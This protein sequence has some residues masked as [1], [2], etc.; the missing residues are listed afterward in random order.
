MFLLENWF[1]VKPSE[2]PVTPSPPCF[3]DGFKWCVSFSFA[4]TGS[5]CVE[6]G[7][8]MFML[9]QASLS[10]CFTHLTNVSFDGVLN[11]LFRVMNNEVMLALCCFVAS[12]YCLKQFRGQIAKSGG[13]AWNFIL[14]IWF[15][16]PEVFR[17][18]P[19]LITHVFW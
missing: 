16:G 3:T 19:I 1:V 5:A 9:I 11:G 8:K 12:R 13:Y 4:V 17:M 2:R 18:P 7:E 15:L 14:P 6:C 10:V